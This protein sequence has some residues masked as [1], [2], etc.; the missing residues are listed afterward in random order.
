MGSMPVASPSP[1]RRLRFPRRGLALALLLVAALCLL[2]VG[3]LFVAPSN[4]RSPTFTAGSIEDFA[5]GSVTYFKDEHVFLARLKDG[6]FVALSD[7]AQHIVGGDCG[8]EA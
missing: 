6:S 1:P 4:E 3:V 7:S 5:P 8:L 2:L